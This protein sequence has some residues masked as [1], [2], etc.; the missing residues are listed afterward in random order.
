MEIDF[1]ILTEGREVAIRAN[2]KMG[3]Q[4]LEQL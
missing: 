4:C 3:K 1:G 2:T